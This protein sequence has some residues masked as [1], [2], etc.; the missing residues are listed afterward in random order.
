MDESFDLSL[1]TLY[2]DD[3]TKGEWEQLDSVSKVTWRKLTKS[4]PIKLTHTY[5]RVDD[6]DD[7]GNHVETSLV[8][9]FEIKDE[10][11]NISKA[12]RGL[13]LTL[14]YYVYTRFSAWRYD[15]KGPFYTVGVRWNRKRV[16]ISISKS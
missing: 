8:L 6:I 9:R 15:D 2:L 12:V 4:Y 10:D 16:L 14:A 7:T 3:L 1:A 5:W 11:W 13:E